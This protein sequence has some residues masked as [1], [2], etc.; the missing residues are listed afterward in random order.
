VTLRAADASIIAEDAVDESWRSWVASALGVAEYTLEVSDEGYLVVDEAYALEKARAALG[1]EKRGVRV[2]PLPVVN[3]EL[4]TA[5]GL[6]AFYI[7]IDGSQLLANRPEDVTVMKALKDGACD[8]FTY[9]ASRS[10]PVDK[11]FTILKG[12][13]VYKKEID[14]GEEYA[15]VLFVQDDGRFDLNDE[16][17]WVTDP[18][19][20]QESAESPGNPSSP[21]SSAGCDAFGV[22]SLL[23]V[24]PLFAAIKRRR[25]GK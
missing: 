3:K 8:S 21:S 1:A 4:D 22:A 18:A 14:P 11:T 10:A 19:W 23:A 24:I 5:G 9:V 25:G 6:A 17:G 16:P 15:L 20:I 2:T 12:G 7:Y 13:A